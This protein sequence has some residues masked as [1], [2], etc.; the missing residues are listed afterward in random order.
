MA[1]IA[2]EGVIGVGKTSLARYLQELLGG[3]LVLEVFEENPFLSS[4]YQDRDRY[5]FQTQLFFLL[6]RYHQMRELAKQPHPIISDYMFAKDKLFAHLTIRGD[7]LAMYE[8]VYGALSESALQPDLVIYLRAETETLMQRIA[9]RDR[10]YERGM[11]EGYIDSLR[12]AYD[13]FF[14][15]YSPRHLL[16]ID[17]SP[18]DF[19]HDA[20]HRQE[21]LQR[22]LSFLGQAP[23]QPELPG[24]DTLEMQALSLGTKPPPIAPAT[25]PLQAVQMSDLLFNLMRLHEGVGDLTRTLRQH[26]LTGEREQSE[27]TTRQMRAELLDMFVYLFNIAD[28]TELEIQFAELTK[29]F[30]QRPG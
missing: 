8:R 20:E 5:A 10:P 24:L 18:I 27:A 23:H 25:P 7:E 16:R 17:T 22:I 3:T 13:Q 15:N 4:F 12:I 26:W 29:M 6:S 9:A 19:V 14:A 1:Y 21:V 2:V 30:R 11:D 28:A